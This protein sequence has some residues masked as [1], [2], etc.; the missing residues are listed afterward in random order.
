M[1]LSQIETL[2]QLTELQPFEGVEPLAIAP[3]QHHAP[4]AHWV[5]H[6]QHRMQARASLWWQQTPHYPE[7]RLGVIGHYA[8]CDE[9]TGV[10]VLQKAIAELQAQGCTL[11]VGPMDGNTWRRYR[12]VSDRGTEP[13]FFLEP[14]NPDEWNQHFLAA[15][16]Q[17]FATYSSAL[18]ADLT[19]RDER[20]VAVGDRLKQQGVRVR[21]LDL[22]H[23]EIELQRI[24]HLSLTSFQ[25]NLLYSPISEAE[26]LAQYTPIKPY[27]QPDL[28]LLAE[29][30]DA[31]IGYLFAIPDLAQAKRGEAITTAIIKTVAVLPGRT[32]AGL[33]GYLVDQGQAIAQSLGY[34]RVIH[35]LMHDSNTSRNIS[36]RFAQTI[37]RYTLYGFHEQHS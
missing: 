21:S 13:P 3:F 6:T 16:F 30:D 29:Q 20:M 33:G 26:F 37:R 32:R 36:G 10:L 19:Q 1:M 31:L 11:I 4:D 23:F 9:A 15:G 35:A 28:V 8:A 24:F 34:T 25:Q 12:W 14:D 18:N 27:I 7:H 5:V 17:A 2:E 22:N